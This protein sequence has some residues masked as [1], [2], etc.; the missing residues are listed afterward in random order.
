MCPVVKGLSY[1]AAEL[2]MVLVTGESVLDWPEATVSD[3][4]YNIQYNTKVT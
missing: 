4:Q 1:T 2:L 3:V